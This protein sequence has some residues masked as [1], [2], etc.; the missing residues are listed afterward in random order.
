MFQNIHFDLNYTIQHQ[1]NFAITMKSILQITTTILQQ[2][3]RRLLLWA[4]Y[5]DIR[6]L[7]SV[8]LTNQVVEHL[9]NVDSFFGRRLYKRAV[10]ELP[11]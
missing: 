9:V 2:H 7:D 8:D 6:T 11:C 5:R 10:A 4:L 3:T 1:A